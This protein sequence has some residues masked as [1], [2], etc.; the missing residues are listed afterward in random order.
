[1]KIMKIYSMPAS[2]WL[3][4]DDAI[5]P[6]GDLTGEHVEKTITELHGIKEISMTNVSSPYPYEIVDEEKFVKF[7]L[8]YG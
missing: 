1:M 8:R 7:L 4:L 3:V 2:I 6:Y 5:D